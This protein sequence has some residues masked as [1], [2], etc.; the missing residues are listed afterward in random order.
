MKN[1]PVL[2]NM[3]NT[4]SSPSWNSTNRHWFYIWTMGLKYGRTKC[5]SSERTLIVQ[6][7]PLTDHPTFALKRLKYK[8]ISL[9]L[10]LYL[11]LS[12]L[13]PLSLSF[14][15]LDLYLL[16]LSLLLSFYSFSV[17]MMFL[18]SYFLSHSITHAFPP[19]S[20]SLFPL[21]SPIFLS[22]PFLLPPPLS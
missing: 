18:H 17:P 5:F 10:T 14:P 20:P 15:Y 13:F 1:I 16:F 12:H 4:E 22:L 21:I 9:F 7:Y 2:K 6:P 3:N 19:L 11:P 8:T